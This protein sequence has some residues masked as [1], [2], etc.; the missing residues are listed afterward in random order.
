MW[1]RASADVRE[2]GAVCS[3]GQEVLASVEK[4]LEAVNEAKPKQDEAKALDTQI[5]GLQG[6]LGVLNNLME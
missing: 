4:A 1:I 5:R 6:K 3:E 2:V